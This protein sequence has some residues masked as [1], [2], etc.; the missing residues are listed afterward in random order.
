M[1]HY[2]T[3][4]QLLIHFSTV[5]FYFILKLILLKKPLYFPWFTDCAQKIMILLLFYT[6]LYLTHIATECLTIRLFSCLSGPFYMVMPKVIYYLMNSYLFIN[7][8]ILPFRFDCWIFHTEWLRIS[9][10]NMS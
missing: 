6:Y 1:H 8:Y 5:Y 10:C 7:P 3:P 2:W 4:H 9:G